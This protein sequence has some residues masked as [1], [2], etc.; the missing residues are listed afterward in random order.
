MIQS[1]SPFPGK[2][3]GA[4]D[5]LQKEMHALLGGKQQCGREV[6]LQSALSYLQ[7]EIIFMPKWHILGPHILISFTP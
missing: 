6:F 7:L 1:H 4:G 2:K 3:E 5:I